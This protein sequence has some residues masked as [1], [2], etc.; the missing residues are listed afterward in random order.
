MQILFSIFKIVFILFLP[1]NI[2]F[3]FIF[4]SAL[5]NFLKLYFIEKKRPIPFLGIKKNK[6]IFRRLVIDFPKRFILDYFTLDPNFFKSYG[7][8]MF[9]GRQGSGKTISLVYNLKILKE[10][11]P[12]M[13]IATNMDYRHQD[14][15]IS[16]GD[17][18]LQYNNGEFG[19]AIVIDEIQ[20]WFSSLDSKNFPPE[21][22]NE[23]SQ[24][25]KQRKCI[26]GTAQVFSRIAKPIREQTTFV[27]CPFTVLG[28]L[29]FVRVY[30]ADM[31]DDNERKFLGFPKKMY[32][33]VHDD[34]LRDSFD[35][36][37]KI[38]KAT[39]IGVANTFRDVDIA[40]QADSVVYFNQ[41]K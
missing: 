4:I 24:Q 7:L 20:T 11:Y 19:T 18:I 9:C 16:C 30:D 29:T 28:C 3:F 41:K 8:H 1:L 14:G 13:I 34:D 10:T 26:L 36:L 31:W 2:F 35:T 22:L 12:K 39:K 15:S 33:F 32:F 25:R 6:S 38:Q 40:T 5:L 37:L 17:D 23:V 27:H 21:L